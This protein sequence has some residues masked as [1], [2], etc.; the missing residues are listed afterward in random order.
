MSNPRAAFCERFGLDLPV[1]Q[2]P[3]IGPK[4]ALA[5]AVSAAGGLGSIACAALTPD[6]VRAEVE[7]LRALTDRPYA[8]NFFAHARAAPD[9]E[10]EAGWKR[11]LAAYYAEFGL[12]PDSV[13]PGPER[14]PFDAAMAEL[15]TA[16]RP[17]VV[18]F[19][20]GLPE[21]GLLARVR[22][23]GCRILGCATTVAEARWLAERGVDAVIAQG[24]E[25]GGHRGLFLSDDIGRQVGTMALVPQVVDAVDL[26]V[27]AA[28]GIA[29]ARGAAA[30]FAL[31]AAAVQVGTAYLL[32]E[33]AGLSAAHRAALAESG[34]SDTALTTVFTGRPARGILNRAMREL[35]PISPDAPAFPRAAAALQPLRAAAEAQGSG[36]FTPL[37]S[38]QAAALAR[39]CTAAELTR[40]L[41][42]G[43][44]RLR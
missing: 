33:E 3:M 25:A 8:L 21:E 34:D 17:P 26:P 22:E 29:D 5:P 4:P 23:A 24:V 10:R 31:G 12:D 2:A 13:A 42:S 15:V 28:G 14:A 40:T 44:E 37:W 16:L 32:C 38:G 43:A 36:A 6:G 9:P 11:R 35:G 1:I 7:R 39:P 20:F 41:A 27:I 30:A 18:S 19:H